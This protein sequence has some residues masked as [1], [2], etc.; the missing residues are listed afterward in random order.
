M[1]MSR[2]ETACQGRAQHK[3]IQGG[4][5]AQGTWVGC[6][7]GF[8]TAEFLGL[9]TTDTAG[10]IS[11]CCGWGVCAIHHKICNSISGVYSFKARSAPSQGVMTKN[12]ST[13]NCSL[14]AVEKRLL[15]RSEGRGIRLGTALDSALPRSKQGSPAFWARGGCVC[16]CE[17]LVMSDSL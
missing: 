9:G 12:A 4:R 17:S 14:G 7:E 16:V 8:Y 6:F 10:W 2:E 3:Q 5:K 11:L 15:Y 1:K 13:V